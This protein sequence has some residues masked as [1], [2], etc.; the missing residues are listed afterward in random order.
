MRCLR[1]SYL[2]TILFLIF[3]CQISVLRHHSASGGIPAS[4]TSERP[5]FENEQVRNVSDGNSTSLYYKGSNN[6]EYYRFSNTNTISNSA[7]MDRIE[8]DLVIARNMHFSSTGALVLKILLIPFT[9]GMSLAIP[10]NFTLNDFQMHNFASGPTALT[11]LDYIQIGIANLGTN[12]LNSE[13]RILEVL[14]SFLKLEYIEFS[15]SFGVAG[16]AN[17]KGWSV[18]YDVKLNGKNQ[19]IPITIVPGK[20]GFEKENLLWLRLYVKP[21]VNDFKNNYKI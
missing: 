10:H 13:I 9:F 3:K 5:V 12:D 20:K 19:Y 14:P 8:N 21:D 2:L 16:V 17:T 7:D 11:D 18:S 15:D 6:K 1:Y 4:C